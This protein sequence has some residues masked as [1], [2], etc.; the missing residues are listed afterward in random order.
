M[1]D[2][3]VGD[4]EMSIGHL[5]ATEIFL[6]LELPLL[7]LAP[8]RIIGAH[9][10]AKELKSKP[11]TKSEADKALIAQIESVQKDIETTFCNLHAVIKHNR[12]IYESC[13]MLISIRPGI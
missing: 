11:E 13:I 8:I 5:K 12:L 10:K 9:I 1:S 7:C 3:E 2:G 4:N 6:L